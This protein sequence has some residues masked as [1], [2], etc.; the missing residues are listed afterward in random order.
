MLFIVKAN[1][2]ELALGLKDLRNMLILIL[3]SEKSFLFFTALV[4]IEVGCA[5]AQ[6]GS[7]YKGWMIV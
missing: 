1:M 5:R 6:A 4:H 3:D 7:D 2:V